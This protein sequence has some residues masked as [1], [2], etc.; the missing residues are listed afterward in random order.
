MKKIVI[1]VVIVLVIISMALVLFLKPK[2]DIEPN[3]SVTNNTIGA[4][5][6]KIVVDDKELIVELEDNLSVNELL[7]KLESGSITSDLKEYGGFEKVGN[8]GF[9]LSRSDKYLKAGPR[10]VLLYNGNQ[11]TIL[12]GD[13]TWNYTKLGTITNVSNEELTSILG[14]GDVTVTI[15]K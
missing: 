5:S 4:D 2:N 1:I 11:V 13:N 3:E 6:I 12:Y 7:D 9:S 8:L 15:T 14:E 10:D